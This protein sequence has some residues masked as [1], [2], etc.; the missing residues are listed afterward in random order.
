MR[1]KDKYKLTDLKFK[2]ETYKNGTYRI[3][4]RK[5]RVYVYG[6]NGEIEDKITIDGGSLPDIMAWLEREEDER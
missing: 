5:W 3:P 4:V 2:V 6:S 1:N